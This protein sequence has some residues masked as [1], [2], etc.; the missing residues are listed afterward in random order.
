LSN[1]INP[2]QEHFLSEMF[3]QK[4]YSQIDSVKKK[5]KNNKWLLFLPP[6]EH[7][8]IGL[9]FSK[10][11]LLH[12][13]HDVIYL[14]SNVPYSSLSQISKSLSIKNIL[15]FS[16]SNFSKKNILQ[17]TSLLNKE[18]SKCNIF[19]VSNIESDN[20]FLK[21]NKIKLINNID[22]FIDVISK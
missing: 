17:T 22:N 21:Q 15:L 18:F 1:K 7:H 14:G 2:A 13:G 6:N 3:K 4:I 20:L 19:L 10:F 9:L 8:E 12:Y 16:V 11:I 5:T